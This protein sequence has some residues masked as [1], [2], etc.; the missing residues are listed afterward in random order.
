MKH[1][2]IV[3]Y[4]GEFT[5]RATLSAAL[6]NAEDRLDA[7]KVVAARDFVHTIIGVTPA[8]PGGH[9]FT[10]VSEWI[11]EDRKAPLSIFEEDGGVR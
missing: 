11:L 6:V 4:R 1:A 5:P 10:A 9:S 8:F 3:L 2:F 7:V